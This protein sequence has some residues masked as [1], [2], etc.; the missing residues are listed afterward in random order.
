[1]TG[2][3]NKTNLITVNDEQKY[4]KEPFLRV[5][6]SGRAIHLV[7]SG[8]HRR[9]PDCGQQPSKHEHRNAC[10]FCKNTGFRPRYVSRRPYAAL[11]PRSVDERWLYTKSTPG[12]VGAA[13]ITFS[14]ELADQGDYKAVLWADYIVSG[15]TVSGDHYPDK[16]YKTDNADGLKKVTIITAAYTYAD[17]LRE[18]FAAVVPFTKG[19]TAKNDL[20]ATLVRPLTKVTIAEKNTEMIG[21]CKDMTATYTVPSEFNAFSE[22]VSPT[23]TYDAT[24]IT[25]SMDGTDITINGNN[26]KILFSDY[27]FTTADATL[28]GIKLTF[29]GTGS[30]TM[31][32]RDI[33]ANIPLK[34]NN[35]VRAAGNLITVGNDPAVTLSVDMTT[36]WVSQDA[37]DIS[38][39]VKVGDFYYADGTWSTAL[40]A[41]KTCI[42]IVFQ[43]DPSRIGDKEKQVLA[44]KGVATPHGLVMSLKTVTKSLMSWGED[45]DFSEL[46][47]CTDKVACNA[48]INGLLNYTTVIDYAAANNKEL[49]NFY[50]AFKAVKDYVVQAPEK[51]TGWY[52]PSIG[53][54]YDFTANLGGLPSWDD[55]INEGN[56]L[57]PNLYRWSNQTE[58][59][60]KINAYFEPLGTGNYDAIPNGSYQKFFSSSTYSDSGIWTWFVGKQANVVQCWHNVRYNS[61]SAVRPILA[62]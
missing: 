11:H 49:E 21:K 59:V 13:N 58:L 43:T 36:D 1:M 10:R 29:T 3:Y 40:D 28:G 22:E 62:F 25:T 56:D 6:G 48:D 12:A 14:F 17:Q 46:T 50:P 23:A 45:H 19:A 15:A 18:A 57:T 61:D 4:E 35:W 60:S 26:C 20:T 41:N 44:A 24:Y 16:Y 34:R 32:D 42:G 53:Q 5:N 7:Q 37:T 52:L 9:F 8:R 27:V 33:P 30:I 31:N 47:K 2:Q 38:D 54:W 51:T 55:A 39:I